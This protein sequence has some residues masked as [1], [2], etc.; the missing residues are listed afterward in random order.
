M[1]IPLSD[2][3]LA[4]ADFVVPGAR[5]ADVGCDHGYLS[6]YLLK[7]QLASQV[8]ASDINEGPLQSAVRNAE[9]FGVRDQIHFFLADGVRNVPRDFDTLI[10]AGMGADTMISILEAAP[11]LKSGQYKLILQCQSRRPALREY[12]SKSGWQIRKETLAE[13]GKFIY[14]ILEAVFAPAPPLSPAETHISPALMACQSE[15]LPEFYS[16]VCSGL[17]TSINGLTKAGQTEKAA[18]FQQILEELRAMYANRHV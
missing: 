8:I 1:N 13:D 3:L 16:R 9:K 11:W 10:C 7:N 5:V 18:D 4:C 17:Q 6:I 14:P 12:L 15:L 2:R